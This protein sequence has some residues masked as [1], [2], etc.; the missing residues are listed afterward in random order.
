MS[1]SNVVFNLPLNLQVGTPI[2]PLESGRLGNAVITDVGKDRVTVVTDF[3][4]EM[5]FT[6]GEL[7]ELFGEPEWAAEHRMYYETNT[8]P[9]G[10]LVERWMTQ[11]ELL[12][13]LVGKLTGEIPD[14]DN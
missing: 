4:N 14:E 1:E 5:R 6:Y 13:Q 3:G 7:R 2:V 11:I 9:K 10:A 8:D 12:Q